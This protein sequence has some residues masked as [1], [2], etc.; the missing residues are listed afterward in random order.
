[1]PRVNQYRCRNCD[2]PCKT[3]GG[4]KRHLSDSD[5]CQ[6]LYNS[7]YRNLRNTFHPDTPIDNAGPPSSPQRPDSPVVDVPEQQ[8][9]RQPTVEDVEDKGDHTFVHS[10]TADSHR[11]RFVQEYPSPAGIPT[12]MEKEP[13]MFE[14]YHDEDPDAICGPFNDEDDY[15]LAKWLVQNVGQKKTDSFLRLNK[16]SYLSYQSNSTLSVLIA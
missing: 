10:P 9:P 3:V 2:K 8:S 14:R 7:T 4:L 1:M 11:T 12:S 13:T 5:E 15:E 6:D 16:V